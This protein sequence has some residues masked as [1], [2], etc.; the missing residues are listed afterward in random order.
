MIMTS[1]VLPLQRKWLTRGL[2]FKYRIPNPRPQAHISELAYRIVSSPSLDWFIFFVLLLDFTFSLTYV[3]VSDWTSVLA[4]RYCNYVIVT[5]YM[6][7]AIL[8]VGSQ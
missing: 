8:K 2:R 7:E 5:I 3:L 6:V 1:H 4:L